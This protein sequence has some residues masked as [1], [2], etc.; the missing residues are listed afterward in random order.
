VGDP[1]F[2]VARV[3]GRLV[4]IR[5]EQLTSIETIAAASLACNKAAREIGTE[6]ICCA[7]FRPLRVLSPEVANA[8]TDALRSNN[9]MT[10]RTAAL[11]NGHV[12]F[13]MQME[14]V[15]REANNPARRVFR[16]AEALLSWLGEIATARELDRARE[17]LRSGSEAPA[18]SIASVS[19]SSSRARARPGS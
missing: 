2:H 8:L 5:Y 14:R 11:V 15:I 13:G 9:A 12:T 1:Q 17:F 3:V 19:V 16:E 7:D 10:A 18:S 4:E 6:P